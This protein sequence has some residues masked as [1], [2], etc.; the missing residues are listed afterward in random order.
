MPGRVNPTREPPP[1]DG[2]A[3]RYN[4]NAAMPN[5]DPTALTTQQLLRENFWLRELLESRIAG[6][7]QRMDAGD[8]AVQL[9]QAFADRTPT[10]KDVQHEVL[11]L[12]EVAMEK[13]SGIK[14]AVEAAFEAAGVGITKSEANFIKQID[15]QQSLINSKTSNL[16]ARISDLKDRM[17]AIEARG[18]GQ[19]AMWGWV[20]GGIALMVSLTIAAVALIN[21]VAK[22]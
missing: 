11:Q 5:S 20:A 3:L 6:I 9:L 21:L 10:T 19:Q 13:F 22:P 4:V 17:T 7:E 12:R 8:K 15:S 1:P 16:E 2:G 14:S 18:G